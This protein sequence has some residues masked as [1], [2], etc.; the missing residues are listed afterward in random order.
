MILYLSSLLTVAQTGQ[1]FPNHNP[2]KNEHFPSKS[3]SLNVK[4]KKKFCT[5]KRKYLKP[6]SVSNANLKH[7]E[8][9]Q[10]AGKKRSFSKKS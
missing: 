3:S 6:S 10:Q 4:Y 2:N 5:L 8:R 1:V 9:G 7:L